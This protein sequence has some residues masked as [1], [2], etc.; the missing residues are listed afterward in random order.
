MRKITHFKE[1]LVM[2]TGNSTGVQSPWVLYTLGRE[3]H[4]ADT[5]LFREVLKMRMTLLQS[6]TGNEP[7]MV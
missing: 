2:T 5:Y 1:K 7:D 3:M 4:L 6:V